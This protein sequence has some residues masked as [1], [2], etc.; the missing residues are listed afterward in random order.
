MN[1][2]MSRD[3]KSRHT[4]KTTDIFEMAAGIIMQTSVQCVAVQPNNLE[5]LPP[6]ELDFLRELPTTW[7]E[8]RFIEGYPGK[9]VVLARKDATTGQWYIAGLNALKE[10][11][12]LTLDLSAFGPLSRLYLDSKASEPTLSSLKLGK[13]GFVKLTL[14]PNGGFIIK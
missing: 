2:W 8:T 14:Q 10:P 12:A 13:K 1:K 11:L 5:E 9:Y 4:R 7:E 6:F 3:N